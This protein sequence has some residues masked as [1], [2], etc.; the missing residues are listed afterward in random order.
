MRRGKRLS[1][2]VGQARLGVA[3]CDPDAILATPVETLARNGSDIRRAA[4]MVKRESIIEVIVGLP[5]NMDGTEGA[6]ARHARSWAGKL[7]NRIAPVPVRLV[8]ERLSTVTAH[9]QLSASGRSSRNHRSVVD[10]AAAI[11]ILETALDIERQTGREPGE[12]VQTER[13]E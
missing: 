4:Q 13:T 9:A 5:L 3:T 10:Q 6:S 11:I 8:D 1:I 12:L 2:D 7:A